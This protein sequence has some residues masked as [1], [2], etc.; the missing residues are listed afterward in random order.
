MKRSERREA[1]Q[2]LRDA[3]QELLGSIIVAF[4]KEADLS[5]EDLA[6]ES[7]VDR[8]FMSKIETGQ[9]AVSLLTLMRLGKTL[10]RKTSDFIIELE[11]RMEEA[12]AQGKKEPVAEEKAKP[13]RV[14]K[15]RKSTTPKKSVKS[16]K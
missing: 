5:Q 10:G 8:S 1:K 7:G 2:E 3:T 6:Y 12:T 15:A 13:V 14:T 16:K 11:R 4:R 9:T